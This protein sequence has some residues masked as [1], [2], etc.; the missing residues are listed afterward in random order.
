MSATPA[1]RSGSFKRDQKDPINVVFEKVPSAADERAAAGGKA[2]SKTTFS[3][4]AQHGIIGLS[5]IHI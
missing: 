5:L 1:R 4:R 3:S 2:G